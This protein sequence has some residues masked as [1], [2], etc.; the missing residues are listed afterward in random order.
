[1]EKL[2][3][4]EEDADIDLESGITV[5]DLLFKL[6]NMPKNSFVDALERVDDSGYLNI[7]HYRDET[8]EEYQLR[9]AKN[10]KIEANTKVLFKEQRRKQYLELKK[11]FEN[12]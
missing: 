4:V 12:E 5:G 8:D 2:K 9:Q 10:K 3:I 11:E 1:M 7:W 6:Q